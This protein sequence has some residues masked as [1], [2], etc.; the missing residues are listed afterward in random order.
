MRRA[1]LALLLLASATQALAQ[2]PFR[3]LYEPPQPEVVE[4]PAP[5]V[6]NVPQSPLPAPP[7]MIDGFPVL[8]ATGTIE[9]EVAPS[10]TVPDE[11]PVFP[12]GALALPEPDTY[13][14]SLRAPGA[15]H[16][17]LPAPIRAPVTPPAPQ[18]T[19][20]PAQ[21]EAQPE[22]ETSLTASP[23]DSEEAQAW[24][25]DG[26]VLAVSGGPRPSALVYCGGQTHLLRVGDIIP[27]TTATI[28][29]IDASGVTLTRHESDQ[30][31]LLAAH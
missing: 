19:P 22:A 1:L 8:P 14:A 2:N 26:A 12:M 30:R 11:A 28:T 27:G 7:V 13:V 20:E 29:H 24:C 3:D 4:A 23:D 18:E 6:I 21:D 16:S 25:V 31:L 15:T 9:T 17:N 10:I 5:I